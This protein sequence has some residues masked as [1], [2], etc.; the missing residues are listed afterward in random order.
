MLLCALKEVSFTAV[1]NFRSLKQQTVTTLPNSRAVRST[2]RRVE[3][4]RFC[5]G[6]AHAL[7]KMGHTQ[8]ID[9]RYSSPF[10]SLQ[11]SVSLTLSSSLCLCLALSEHHSYHR[12]PD[13][14]CLSL[15]SERLSLV[16]TKNSLYLQAKEESLH[17]ISLSSS[18]SSY[19]S[20]V[21]LSF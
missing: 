12:V 1:D 5:E 6:F 7:N 8:T 3:E 14:N 17:A 11:L 13:G 10:V 4:H 20:S 19:V 15:D 2:C 9:T 18:I 16:P 21:S